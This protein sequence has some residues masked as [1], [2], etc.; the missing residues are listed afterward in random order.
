[1]KLKRYLLLLLAVPALALPLAAC[2]GGAMNGTGGNPAL[3]PAPGRTAPNISLTS[4]DGATVALASLRGQPV[5]LNFWASW[6]GPCRSEMDYLQA[7]ND[8]PEFQ[9]A[10][11]TLIEVNMQEDAA[12]VRDYLAE[13]GLDL[14]VLLDSRA[15]AARAYNVNGI[16]ASF[17]IDGNGIIKMVKIGAYRDLNSLQRDVRSLIGSQ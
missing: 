15:T 3:A 9:A 11:F 17:F 6:C 14:T 5:L 4:L 10:G 7:V 8:A 1:M 16:P 12:T 13:N 2:S